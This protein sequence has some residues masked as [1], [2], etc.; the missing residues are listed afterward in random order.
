MTQLKGADISDYQEQPDFDKLKKDLGFVLTKATE[1]VGFTARTLNRN[2]SEMRRVGL[3]HGFYH[4]ARGGD[5]IAE[6]NYFV[7]Q[8]GDYQK[9]ELL[10]LDWEI[11]HQDPAQWCLQW[12]QHVE[13]RT[14]TKPLIYMNSSAA[15]FSNWSP[16]VQNNNGLVIASYGVDDGLPHGAPDSAQWPYWAIWQYTSRGAVNGIVGN[17]DLDIFYGDATALARYGGAELVS[18]PSQ[19]AAARATTMPDGSYSYTV[20]AG[21]SMSSIAQR[22][23]MSLPELERANPQVRNPNVIYV[24]ETLQIPNGNQP[25]QLP[26]NGKKEILE[27]INPIL[28]DYYQH[29]IPPALISAIIQVESGW[30]PRAVGDGGTSFGLFQLH[31]GGQAEDAF[32]DGHSIEDLYDPKINT[33]Y[34]MRYIG[35]AWDTH[36]GWFDPSNGD[37]WIAFA[38]A[39]GHPGGSH[40]DPATTRE[41]NALQTAYTVLAGS[42]DGHRESPPLTLTSKGEVAEFA[43]ADQFVPGKTQYACGFFACATALSMAPVGQR[44]KLTKQQIIDY[45]EQWYA[46][47][48]GNNLLANTKGMTGEQEYELLRQIGLHYQT[49]D[50]NINIVERWVEAGY[51]VL[52]SVEEISVFDMELG[53]NPYTSFA[54]AG[55]HVILVTGVT[56][57]GNILCRDSANCTDLN[58]PDTLRPG[59]RK[60][61]ASSMKIHGAVVIVPP[62]LPRPT[63]AVP[64]ALPPQ[65][66]SA[67]IDISNPWVSAYFTQVSA[68]PTR[69]QCKTTGKSLFAGILHGWQ[70]MNGA[71]RLPIGDE[72]RCGKRAIYQKCESGILLYDPD[73]EFDA[74][75]GPWAPCYLLKLDSPLAK[76]LLGIESPTT[77]GST[78]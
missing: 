28:N 70:L 66:I 61:K 59:P 48:E 63:S 69:W 46:Q 3:Q 2:K 18:V 43:E 20:Q 27:R 51:P 74:P 31:I 26:V 22:F 29:G 39:S 75:N 67:M 32:K 71:P 72:V 25:P 33:R 53:C 36:K 23:G 34:A 54:P 49:T 65:E 11:Q 42:Q 52:V 6:A 47:Y 35:R 4:F 38:I 24:G 60:Y 5:P 76:Q 50:E 21:D 10:M 1:G 64:P 62:W 40:N 77:I 56:S 17:V 16:V 68:N 9:G 19:P 13:A 8:I 12:L 15:H 7:D 45:A 57:D 73:K 14:G 44:P 30:D 41:A 55:L 58:I 37:W 78:K